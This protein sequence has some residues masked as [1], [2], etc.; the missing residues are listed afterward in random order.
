MT[1]QPEPVRQSGISQKRGEHF[2]L[3]CG[4]GDLVDLVSDSQNI[5]TF[6]YRMVILVAKHMKSDVC[7][8]Y[9]YDEDGGNLVLRATRGLN[10][11][12]VDRIAMRPGE[13]LIGNTFETNRPMRIA[14]ALSNPLFKY[15][16][17]ADEDRYHSFLA[18]PISRG[19]QRIGV[20]AV[21]HESTDYFD[22]IDERALRASAS[23][24]AGALENIRLLF[25][26]HEAN[27]RAA[28]ANRTVDLRF[29]KGK[30]AAKGYGFGGATV[31]RKSHANLLSGGADADAR[32]TIDDFHRAIRQTSRQL[33]SLQS[34][35]AE[36]LPE[37]ASLIF[38]AHFMILRD[39]KFIDRISDLIREG[40]GPPDAIRSVARHYISLFSTSSHAYIR[41]KVNDMEDLAGRLLKNLYGSMDEAALP[42]EKCIVVAAELYPSEILKIASENVQGI[43]LVKGGVTSHVSILARSLKIPMLIADHP[44]LLDIKEG[45]PLLLDGLIGNLYVNPDEGIIRKFEAQKAA[46]MAART[47]LKGQIG[48]PVTRDGTRIR[49]LANIN[50]LSE[51]KDARALQ[52]EGIGLYRTEFPFI[53]RPTFP[54]EEEQYVIYK[55][56]TNEMGDLE[57]TIR[58]LDISGDKALVYSDATRGANPDLG[59]R[60]IRFSLSHRSIF[61]Q[62]IRA[63]LRAGA[64]CGRLR[65]MFPMI[66]SLDEF[67]EAR[68]I[69]DDCINDLKAENLAHQLDPSVGMMI[70]VPSVVEI[71]PALARES[72]FFSI[73]TNDFV[74]Y[75]LAVDRTNEKVAEYYRP[76]HPSVLR[77]LFRIVQ[78]AIRLKKDIAV[79]GE[80]GHEVEYLPFLLGIG[81]RTLSVDPQYLPVLRQRIAQ[82][83]LSDAENHARLLLEQDSLADAFR[84]LNKPLPAAHA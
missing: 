11:K 64:A 29:V 23:Q 34:R 49:L 39:P 5:E 72:D 16:K 71:L 70:E 18:V 26:L 66:S 19:V 9:L 53:V 81:L 80:M 60:S 37:S 67:R 61:E 46:N 59:L 15:F 17:E 12:A 24:L 4:I 47:T 14:D 84:V 8:I 57:I 76:Y 3:L 21:Q 30:V 51:I 63:I 75:T 77:G 48:F 33:M 54:S 56:L 58:T 27:G 78:E 52:A 31:F 6:L 55:H 68:G 25:N 36:R 62:Q 40:Q 1:E 43:V 13:G 74:Q 2:Q 32:F 10:P 22:E 7:S 69:V 50:L 73:G 83:H 79:C 41:E 20:M 28:P 42:E 65:I 38:T 35:L 45:T 44:Q 82:I